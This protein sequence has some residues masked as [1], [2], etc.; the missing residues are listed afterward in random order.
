[1][2]TPRLVIKVA[3]LGTD[4]LVSVPTT[5]T[6][7]AADVYTRL[8]LDPAGP[9]FT[10]LLNESPGADVVKRCGDTI[11][12]SLQRHHRFSGTNFDLKT[13]T[14]IFFRLDSPAAENLPWEALWH[15]TQNCFVALQ[16]PWPIA[17]L[18]SLGQRPST[19][20]TVEPQLKILAV[21]AAA[22]GNGP[23]PVDAMGEWQEMWKALS[24]SP[25][26]RRVRIYVIYCQ[27]E[28]RD[29]L[30]TLADPRV[31]FSPLRSDDSLKSAVDTLSPNIIHFF[32]HGSSDGT[33]RL[34]LARPSDYDG[35]GPGTVRLAPS[36]LVGLGA[37]SVWLMTLNCC[38]G[39]Q[40]TGGLH[41]MAADVAK[42]GIPAVVAMRES[43]D[44]RKAHVFAGAFYAHLVNALGA[45][46]P[47]AVQAEAGETF[48]ISEETWV[49]AMHPPRKALSNPQPDQNPCC[50][51]P[52]VYEQD[53]P[54]MLK[55]QPRSS[56]LRPLLPTATREGIDNCARQVAAFRQVRAV[57]QEQGAPPDALAELDAHIAKAKQQANELERDALQALAA[58]P[59]LT[60]L[61]ATL[62]DE[63]LKELK[64]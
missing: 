42:N 7:L 6:N 57:M 15:R 38:Q 11:Y 59:G 24:Q 29:A 63:R 18:S 60:D 64:P 55:A 37:P 44:F 1:M 52:V 50:T 14:P 20:S 48:E 3:P 12:E 41:S 26:A 62:I 46:L 54:L 40:A 35:G 17:R 16:E 43:V 13:R 61:Q 4:D 10:D 31:S 9:P 39:G 25:H 34:E 23:E 45:Y 2:P 49:N 53:G 58:G 8:E 36:D 56:S 19:I 21:L 28:V 32:C 5:P 30:E 22:R 51:L 27:D 33:R 47:S